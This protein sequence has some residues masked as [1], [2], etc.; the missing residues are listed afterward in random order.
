MISNSIFYAD[1]IFPNTSKTLLNSI[2]IIFDIPI[3]TLSKNLIILFNTSLLFGFS[4]TRIINITSM[5][6][7]LFPIII[8]FSQL[9]ISATISYI[10]LGTSISK[11]S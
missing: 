5:S 7:N 10:L 1:L 6:K 9:L 11:T 8:G 3:I 2:S 4:K